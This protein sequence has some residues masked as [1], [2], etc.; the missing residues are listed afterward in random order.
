MLRRAFEDYRKITF[1][2]HKSVTN[3]ADRFRNDWSSLSL[4]ETM[5]QYFQLITNSFLRVG[6][7]QQDMHQKIEQNIVLSYNSELVRYKKKNEELIFTLD[8]ASFAHGRSCKT[9]RPSET[10]C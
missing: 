4:S 8:K 9:S 10:S 1:D 6:S 2:F 7:V 3:L 5:V